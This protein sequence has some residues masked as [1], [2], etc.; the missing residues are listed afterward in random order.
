M[1]G[2]LSPGSVYCLDS[3]VSIAPDQHVI[4]I[5]GQGSSGL[6]LDH[7]HRRQVYRSRHSTRDAAGL[8][9]RA[10]TSG[11]TVD[12][13]ERRT[14]RSKLHTEYLELSSN[15]VLTSAFDTGRS[16]LTCG[17]PAGVRRVPCVGIGVLGGIVEPYQVG[18]RQGSGGPVTVNE[19]IF[20]AEIV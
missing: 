15:S 8:D 16:S 11:F 3:P 17:S 4:N 20:K 5:K 10:V 13:E 12:V 9:G 19:V 6:G 14:V 1:P 18:S 2:G 7:D